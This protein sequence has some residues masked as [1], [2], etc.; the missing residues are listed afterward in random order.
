MLK[1]ALDR[2]GWKY[3]EGNFTI[4]Q[5]GQSSKAQI[6]FSDAM[7]M[8]LQEDGTWSMVGDPYHHHGELRKYYGKSQ[9]FARD[10]TSAY[11][12]SEA[13]EA[14]EEQNFYCV[15]NEK[16]VVGPDGKIKMLF[17]SNSTF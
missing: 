14:L 12:I 17:Q 8:S 4:S 7:G 1:K 2:L 5:Y 13:T 11:A 10:L 15:D 6:K 16:G 9:E 3:E